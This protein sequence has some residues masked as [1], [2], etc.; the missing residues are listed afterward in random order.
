MFSL[1]KF[2]ITQEFLYPNV[3]DI[4]K[5]IGSFKMFDLQTTSHKYN[6]VCK[7]KSQNPALEFLQLALVV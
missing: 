7:A 3:L 2:I 6:F 4:L 5:F 1:H